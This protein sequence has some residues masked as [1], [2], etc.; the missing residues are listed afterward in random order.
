MYDVKSKNKRHD[1]THRQDVLSRSV[2]VD[3]P[4][5]FDA[6]R[7]KQR[8]NV[9]GFDGLWWLLCCDVIGWCQLELIQRA[10]AGFLGRFQHLVQ[11]QL[12]CACQCVTS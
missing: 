5:S 9:T 7:L 6:T 10:A 2:V 8:E 1:V 11:L 4:E 12:Q 3:R